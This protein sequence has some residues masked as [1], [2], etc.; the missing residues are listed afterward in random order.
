MNLQLVNHGTQ[1]TAPLDRAK[2][3]NAL[4][5]LREEWEVSAEGESLVNIPASVSLMLLNIRT[6]LG[7]TVEEQKV[8]LGVR[9]YQEAFKKTQGS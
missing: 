1:R 9:L 7:M 5:T 6:K 4:S 8:V 2:P 3:Y